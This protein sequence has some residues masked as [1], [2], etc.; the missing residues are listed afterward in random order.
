MKNVLLIMMVLG[1]AACMQKD[2]AVRVSSQKT[3][4]KTVAPKVAARSE[5]VFYNG[6]TYQMNMQ[7]QANGLFDLSIGG[8]GAG[9]QKDA[10]AVATS[11][12]RYFGCVEGK[13]GKLT[14]APAYVGSSW[15]MSARCA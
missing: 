4:A 11:S 7:P 1:L 6:K 8:M 9:Q 10:V 2:N 13:T 3:V 5:P 14:N 15:K 12:L